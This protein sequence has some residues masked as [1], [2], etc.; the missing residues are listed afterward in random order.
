MSTTKNAKRW[1]PISRPDGTYCSPG[2]G[3]GCTK[4]DHDRAQSLGKA[5]SERMGPGWKPFVWE[6]GGWHYSANLQINDSKNIQIHP[7][8]IYPSK[9]HIEGT[10]KYT[11]YLNTNPQFVTKHIDPHA[12]LEEAAN[13]LREH[14]NELQAAHSRLTQATRKIE[15]T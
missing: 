11:V 15:S 4:K 1:N 10:S 14:A 5:L 12:A 2:C 13:A 7:E 3:C 8:C 9:E 6:N